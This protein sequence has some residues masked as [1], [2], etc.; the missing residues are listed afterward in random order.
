M[1]DF[2]VNI[3]YNF[4]FGPWGGANQFLKALKR[5]LLKRGF[6]TNDATKA[7]CIIFNSHH[8]LENL[9]HNKLK[10]KNLI[11]I[12]RVD[13]PVFKIR[14]KDIEIDK[15]IYR[16]NDLIADGTIFQSK[17]SREENYKLE[18]KKNNYEI[19]IPNAPDPTIF[20]KKKNK[21]FSN[22]R[23]IRLIA[24]SWSANWQKG[25]KIYEYLDKY[26]DFSKYK[27]IFIG[28]SPLKFKNIKWI[29][30]LK[31]K[32]L[33][34]Y[35]KNHDIFI[36]ASQ[37]DPCSNSL[38]EA[39]HCG[40]PSIVRNDGGHPEII[41]KGGVIFKGKDDIIEKIE[42]VAQNYHYYQNNIKLPSLDSVV[43]EY[44]NFIKQIYQDYE[45]KVYIPKIITY[46]NYFKLKLLFFLL[47]VKYK[48]HF[49]FFDKMFHIGFKIIIKII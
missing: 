32:E 48:I 20:N 19:I 3:L 27:M 13:G 11:C 9:L 49:S 16:I 45:N 7:N 36:I 38:I 1:T 21:T 31:S 4:H 5:I 33:A 24:T 22:K 42:K 23:K 25:F 40:L 26:I 17:W 29:K 41:G 44:Y 15:I 46:L 12:H 18:M 28:N 34:E 47:N 8:N 43:D 30:P 35:L 39:L 2:K 6:Y 10:N 37:K 14:K